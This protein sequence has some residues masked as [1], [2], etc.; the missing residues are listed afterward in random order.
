MLSSIPVQPWL[1]SQ[2][3]SRG[4]RDH[5]ARFWLA[6]PEDLLETFWTGALGEATRG[7]IQQLNPQFPFTTD[8]VEFRDELNKILQKGLDQPCACQTLLATFLYSPR[9]KFKIASPDK[10]LPAWLLPHYLALYEDGFSEQ[11][12]SA[13]ATALSDVPEPDFGEFPSSLQ[14]LLTNRIQLN[15][16]LGLSN[17]YYIDPEDQEIC[18]ELMQL[19]QQFSAALK[20]CNE[21]ELESL[22]ATDLGDRYWAMVRSGIQKESMSQE[23]ERIKQEAVV[24]LL[25]SEGGGF[26][27]PGAVNAFLVAMLFYVPGTMKVDDAEEKVPAWL[28]EG[29]KEVF[30]KSLVS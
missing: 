28:L 17:L 15:R 21:T 18:Q 1:S 16:M 25:P 12:I 30:A 20:A 10:W 3:L 13:E 4:D 27:K 8:Q 26:G 14:E 11:P 22:F 5:L 24:R 29:Y 9:G 23:D 2:A 6:A 19:R 7:L